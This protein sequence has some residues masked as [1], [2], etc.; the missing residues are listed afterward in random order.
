MKKTI[1]TSLFIVAASL[2]LNCYAANEAVT[3]A[4]LSTGS[5]S[6]TPAGLTLTIDEAVEKGLASSIAM[7]KVKNQAELAALISENAEKSKNDIYNAENKLSNAESEISDGRTMAY[8]SLDKIDIAQSLLDQGMAPQDIPLMHPVTHQL[9]ATI[10]A[11]ANIQQ[12][13][14]DCHL[15]AYVSASDVIA[16]VQNEL[17]SSKAKV[18]GALEDLDE[19]TQE[20][21]ASKSKYDLS[22]QFAMT[23]IANKLSTSTISSLES[24][25][26]ADLMVEMAKIQDKMTSYSVN[27]YKNKIALLIQNSYCEALKQKMLLVAKDK[28]MQRAQLQ[29]EYADYA[30]KVGAKSKDD[31][32]LAKLYYDGSVMAYE[33]QKKDY[34]NAMTELKKNMNMPLDTQLNLVEAQASS[35]T[36][37]QL[38][39]GLNSGLTIR[40][41]IKMAEA[42]VELYKD[43][44]AAVCGSSYDEDDNQYKEANLLLKKAEIELSSTKL[45]VE[46]SIRTSYETLT[47]MQRVLQ[48]ANQL[49]ENAEETVEIAKLKYEVGFGA[50]NSLLKSMNLQDISGTMAEVIAAE[51]NLASIEQK[52]IEAT[53]GFNLA[54]AK[55]LNDIG[56]LPYK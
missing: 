36:S 34:N 24:K 11:K 16:K 9:L 52:V 55:Y 19:G 37:Y 2:G 27:I 53:D 40:L 47:T 32:N 8:D 41:E 48:T 51:E 25:H 23:S 26:L 6:I 50:D 33:L 1:L 21:M 3:A 49:K 14:N 31:M 18:N 45:E 42:Q 54:Q 38:I 29:Y 7:S 12:F 39:Q 5:E 43:L 10:P 22:T 20:Y 44:R 28:T 17:N 35:I 13:L 56:I 15:S 4:G 46:S 30:Y